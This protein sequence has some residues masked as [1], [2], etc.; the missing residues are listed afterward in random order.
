MPRSTSGAPTRRNFHVP[1]PDDLY[2]ALQDEA[3]QLQRPA[4]APAR[5]AIAQRIVVQRQARINQAILAY[6]EAMAGTAADLDPDLE[7][8]SLE[9]LGREV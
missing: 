4:N 9:W 1:L 7:A 3:R 6:A 2:H 8:A 5:E